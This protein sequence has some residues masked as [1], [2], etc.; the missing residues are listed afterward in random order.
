MTFE[1]WHLKRDADNIVWLSLDKKNATVNS[2][3]EAVLKELSTLLTQFAADKSMHALVIRSAKKTGFIAGADIEQFEQLKTSEQATQVIR[4]GQ[5]ILDQLAALPFPTLAMIQGFCL[6]GGLE[7]ALACRYRIAEDAP[8]TRLGL[9]EV[10][11]GI[12]PGWGGT[13]RLP[14]LIGAPQALELILSGKSIPAKKAAALGLVDEAVP[15]RQLM[16]AVH[17]YLK[18]KPK[19]HTANLFQRSSNQ[20]WMRLLIGK[21]TAQKLKQ[22]IREDHYPA[23][24]RALQC[25]VKNGVEGE[26]AYIE[27]ATSLGELIVTDTS[28]NLVHVFFLQEQ[29]KSLG[30]KPETPIKHVHVIGA[31]TM[32]GD[33]AAW[34]AL[35]G[36]RVTLQDHAPSSIASSVARAHALFQKRLKAPYEIQA[37]MDRLIPDIAGDGVAQADVVIEA[38]FENLEVKQQLFRHLEK[39]CKPHALLATNTSS[40]PL[41]EINQVLT[42][43]SRLVGI[44]FFNPVAMMQ[45]VEV[46]KGEKTDTACLNQAMGF[47]KQ[48]DR[49]PLPVKSAPGFLVNRVLMPYLIECVYLLQ[50]NIPA[51]V[52]DE[53]ALRFGMPMGPVELADTV[54]LDICL[55]VANN[56]MQ[57]FGGTL[58]ARLK[59][60][61]ENKKLGKKTEEGFYHY[62]NGKALKQKIKVDEYD[63]QTIQ[64]RLVL[65]LLNEAAACLREGI[66]K[67]ADEID[68]GMVFGTGF[69][70]F[71]GGPLHYAQ[72]IGYKTVKDKLT[73]Y[74]HTLGER[75]TPD[76]EW[77]VLLHEQ[78]EE[79][80]VV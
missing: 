48:I 58:P 45:L 4:R 5:L 61:V 1:N 57:Y 18:N 49:L 51:E 44:H 24:Y 80:A 26:Q 3:G 47:V 14:R 25:W 69:A 6:G 17:Y 32:G 27:E 11:L 67:T 8:K 71:R 35:R 64:D 22:K 52:I 59:E 78:A 50:E 60:K 29:L 75:F 34:C 68:A 7:L 28:H 63:L 2:L 43:P 13:I 62:H 23:P 31:G 10:M 70:P 20:K 39:Q 40:I 46:V 15:E 42:Q 30:K 73:H 38:I 19:P 72:S 54:G 79:N 53:A 74:T 33:I 56:L 76:K 16:N 55:S 37:A 36:L 9:P 12:H 77:D 21:L 65:R 41:D 66:V